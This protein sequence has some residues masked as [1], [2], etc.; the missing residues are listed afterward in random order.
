MWD[1]SGPKIRSV[2]SEGNRARQVS[3]GWL[4]DEMIGACLHECSANDI[5]RNTPGPPR[6]A[7]NQDWAAK[8][9]SQSL[10]TILSS[11]YSEY[12]IQSALQPEAVCLRH[13]N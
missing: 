8:N 1:L 12:G 13:Q 5:V 2:S 3:E 10:L 6:T 11:T 9:Y 7:A 4:G